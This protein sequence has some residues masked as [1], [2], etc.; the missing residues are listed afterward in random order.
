MATFSTHRT[1]LLTNDYAG[2]CKQLAPNGASTSSVMAA[3]S[4]SDSAEQWYL[5]L[6]P[7]TGYYYMHTRAVGDAQALDVYND[8]D[9]S[10]TSLTF[11]AAGHFT[12]QYWRFD[13][14]GHGTY[15]LSNNFTGTGV[16]LDT[17]ADTLQPFLD[18][19]DHSGQHWTFGELGAAVV[20]RWTD[21]GAVAG[22]VVG[23]VAGV[24]LIA[25]AVLALLML[26][27]KKRA[28][29]KQRFESMQARV[30][31]RRTRR[32]RWL[33]L[34]G[35]KGA[36]RCAM[37]TVSNISRPCRIRSSSCNMQYQMYVL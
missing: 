8:Q 23:G 24:L 6:A 22:G 2:T 17:Y 21:A 29:V 32:R 14:W 34:K 28:G 10:S 15:R 3:A 18:S 30:S 27:R 4:S 13:F 19:G 1:Y 16:S 7:L 31:P 35:C 25:G 36:R 33:L 37:K 11:A 12:G 5:R 9:T 26:A 20:K